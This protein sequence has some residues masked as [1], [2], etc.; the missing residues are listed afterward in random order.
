MHVLL[1]QTLSV[2]HIKKQSIYVLLILKSLG[3]RWRSSLQ[4][5]DHH[6]H[7]HHQEGLLSEHSWGSV[8]DLVIHHLHKRSLGIGSVTQTPLIIVP[9]MEVL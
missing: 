3:P 4:L 6:Y 2:Y 7:P 8:Q 1:T 9:I 5:Y